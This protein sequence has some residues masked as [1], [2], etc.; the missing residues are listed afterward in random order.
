VGW[1]L[2]AAK[3]RGAI[4]AAAP[5]VVFTFDPRH[6]STCHAEHRATAQIVI[7]A[8]NQMGAAAP[9]V[10]MA[11]VQFLVGPN[12]ATIGYGPAVPA[13]TRPVAYDAT[14]STAG[15]IGGTW[16]YLISDL[17]AHR[18]Q[19]SQARVTAFASAPQEQ[20]RVFLLSLA[21]AVST[22]TDARYDALCK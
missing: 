3:M 19:F 20:R 7:L 10:W 15:A 8:L 2:F 21:E 18:S 9:Q 4:E 13:D 11:E 1:G 14:R 12:E 17:G 16:E 6:G 5:D 22:G